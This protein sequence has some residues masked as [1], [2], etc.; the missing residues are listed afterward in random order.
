ME[1]ETTNQRVYR[2]KPH[3]QKDKNAVLAP[4]EVR[5]NPPKPKP[6]HTGLNKPTRLHD[7]SNVQVSTK[8]PF[9]DSVFAQGF[10]V[11]EVGNRTTFTPS[12]PA[13]IEISRGVYTEMVTDDANL[14]K[15][16]LP[17]YIDYYAVAMLW[18]RI[19]SLKAKN[20]QPLT[21][22]E[23]DLL[24][25]LQTTSFAVP[26][27]IALQLRTLGNIETRTGQHLIPEFPALPTAVISNIGGYFGEFTNPIP[28]AP[29]AQEANEE[30]Q[31]AHRANLVD[32][33]NQRVAM[34]HLHLLYEE[35]PCLGVVAYAI[36]QSLS[37]QPPGEYP[38]PFLYG[39]QRPNQNLLGYKN[40]GCRRSESKDFA[41]RHN[42]SER[43]FPSYPAQSAVNI[44][45]IIALSNLLAK[46]KTFK[47]S[48]IVFPTLAEVGSQSQTVIAVPTPLPGQSCITCELRPDSLTKENESTFGMSIFFL[49]N[50]MKVSINQNNHSSWCL[51]DAPPPSWIENRNSRRENLPIQYRQRVFS[52]VSQYGLAYRMNV[53]KSLVTT[54]R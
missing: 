1:R 24:T 10:T 4:P 51:F 49:S 35:L 33:E 27:P 44:E 40:L 8:N 3:N 2:G 34:E 48:D 20:S 12:A 31:E 14:Q 22:E 28:P 5:K 25:I 50:M 15:L 45:F 16:I 36:T 53:L 29:P 42:I 37:N 26:D 32:F 13:M 9:D 7:T 21:T 19:V 38:P 46:T 52:T 6:V 23:Q 18:F 30:A 47:I 11:N 54:P 17:E 41:L 39:N 43:N